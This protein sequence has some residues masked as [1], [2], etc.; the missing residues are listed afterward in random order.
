M[1]IIMYLVSTEYCICTVVSDVVESIF[2]YLVHWLITEWEWKGMEWQLNDSILLF[3]CFPTV[4]A[5]GQVPTLVQVVDSSSLVLSD[6]IETMDFSMPSYSGAVKGDTT[7]G[8]KEAPGIPSFNPFSFSS[9]K[10]EEPAAAVDSAKEAEQQQQQTTSK[11]EAKAAA[12]AKKA[13]EKAAADKRKADDK[14]AEEA[15]KAEKEARRLEQIEKQKE[16][17]ERAKQKEAEKAAAAPV[18]VLIASWYCQFV[19]KTWMAVYVLVFLILLVVIIISLLYSLSQSAA[20]EAV[21]IKLPEM[22]KFEA[23]DVKLPEMPDFKAPEMPKFSI[24]KLDLPDKPSA[25]PAGK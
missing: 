8:A 3:C 4:D 11:A 25:A 10:E 15:K 1:S 2:H 19:Q 12:E 9:D 21:D 20:V 5:Q 7:T 22:P 18:S 14:A 13:D 23:P 17:V 24:P 16:A 6:K